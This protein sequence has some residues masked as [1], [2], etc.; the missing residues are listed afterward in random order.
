ML[1]AC[2]VLDKFLDCATVKG[3]IS[4]REI[5]IFPCAG[6]DCQIKVL[7]RMLSSSK[8]LGLGPQ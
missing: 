8:D 4:T 7:L 3:L 1:A 6:P 5:F 2:H